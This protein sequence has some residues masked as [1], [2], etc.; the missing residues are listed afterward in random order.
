VTTFI[1]AP[2]TGKVIRATRAILNPSSDIRSGQ[3]RVAFFVSRI[4]DAD[5]Y[6]LFGS[7]SP[8]RAD[9]DHVDAPSLGYACLDATVKNLFFV[10]VSLKILRR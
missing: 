10:N 9:I 8:E 5:F 3:I 2:I 7:F 1:S 6:V 4:D